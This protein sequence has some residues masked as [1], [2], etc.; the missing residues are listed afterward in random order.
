MSD[1]ERARFVTLVSLSA[2]GCL[3]E[4]DFTPCAKTDR[5]VAVDRALDRGDAP[6]DDAAVSD[7]RADIGGDLTLSGDG[8]ATDLAGPD[9]EAGASLDGPV[10]V[11]CSAAQQACE[12]RCVT[13]ASDPRHCGACGRAC[14][15]PN[16]G[17]S[18]CR[19]GVCVDRCPM[20][21][22]LRPGV[23]DVPPAP[24][25]LSPSPTSRSST[26]RPNLRWM[27]PMGA[28]GVRV[29]FCS[30]RDCATPFG[31]E[32]FLGA[33][34]TPRSNLPVGVLFWR[35]R[36]IVGGVTGTAVSATWELFVPARSAPVQT[37]Q[38]MT[39]DFNGDGFT[40]L[41]AWNPAGRI[42]LYLGSRGGLS[43]TLGGSLRSIR[44]DSAALNLAGDTNGDGY[45]DLFASVNG[46]TSLYLGGPDVGT[47]I[48]GLMVS[49]REATAVIKAQGIGDVNCDGYGDALVLVAPL[50]AAPDTL[51]IWA[52]HGSTSLALPWTRAVSLG[53]ATDLLGVGSA[54]FN[55]DACADIAIARRFAVELFLGSTGG[56]STTRAATLNFIGARSL[57]LLLAGDPRGLG[58][59]DITTYYR[60]VLGDALIESLYATPDWFSSTTP[61]QRLGPLG[62][63]VTPFGDVDNDG[64]ADC[65]AVAADGVRIYRGTSAG[66]AAAPYATLAAPG[67]ARPRSA[68]NADF[69]GDGYADLVVTSSTGLTVHAGAASPPASPGAPLRGVSSTIA[70]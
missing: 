52:L 10:D 61:A 58:V 64:H 36:S 16:G 6:L 20:G 46:T 30:T 15:A 43:A 23:C 24:R 65:A 67:D 11:A 22:V 31:T 48:V 69:N 33:G 1:R 26:R 60:P 54:A 18:E 59:S 28:E 29:E 42:D 70:F 34:G 44:A 38:G 3:P 7:A 13:L 5:C 9:S 41:A 27:L 57:G 19:S 4:V 63:G 49:V 37:F 35:A 53:A 2:L 21:T 8:A 45:S 62:V 47:D 40:D 68:A 56:L 55:D 32:E 17:T 66:Y 51:E 12:A 50:A 14:T 25:L 39:L